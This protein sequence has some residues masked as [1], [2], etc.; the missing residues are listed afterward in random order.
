MQCS[1]YGLKRPSFQLDPEMDSEIFVGREDVKKRLEDR[2]KRAIVTGTSLHTFIYGD[3]GSGKTHTLNYVYRFLNKQDLNVL[4][5]LVRQPRITQKSD[6]SDLYA[7]IVSAVSISE[8]FTLFVRVHDSVQTKLKDITDLY[9]RVEVLRGVVENRDLSFI[10]NNY[11]TNRPIEDYAVVKWLSGEKMAAR[12]KAVLN[13]VTDNSDPYVA[14]QTLLAL[15]K[16]FNK[17]GKKYVLLMLDEMESLQ[18]IS[19]EKK[20]M[21]FE[22]F[23]R[24][25][26]SED[27]GLGVLLAHTTKQ[28]LEDVTPM[29]KSNTAIG[30]RIGYPQNYIYLKQFEDMESMK[31]FA[32]QLISALRD[33]KIDVKALAKKNQSNT[34]EHLALDF[35]PFT[36]EAIEAIHQLSQGSGMIKLLLPR[37]IQKVMTDSLGDAMIQN[38]AFVDQEIV[39]KIMS[40]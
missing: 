7:S 30:T 22:E 38:R 11:V 6:P 33:P 3:Y 9:K 15:V 8:I 29:F 35:Y 10:I 21:P 19:S 12:E 28:A 20:Q 23:L 4:P 14:I 18:M 17:I 34:N 37:D 13:V 25:L 26:T 16:L 31:T 36:E 32:R 24:I 1:D 2:L 39:S 27:K 40:T 5:I